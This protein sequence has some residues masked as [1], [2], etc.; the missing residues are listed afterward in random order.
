MGL[1]VID[2]QNL[3]DGAAARDDW[4]AAR[5]DRAGSRDDWATGRTWSPEG[6]PG[7]WRS[8]SVAK[9]MLRNLN[10]SNLG[11]KKR[12]GGI[13]EQHLCCVPR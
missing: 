9:Q 6:R 3:D 8:A 12:L 10:F 7:T 1:M 11:R 2:R 4:A 13:L 5:E